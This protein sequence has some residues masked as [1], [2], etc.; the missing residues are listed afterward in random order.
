M[1]LDTLTTVVDDVNDN[2]A[3]YHMELVNAMNKVMAS[4]AYANYST[5]ASMTG[6]VTLT[7]ASLPLLSYSPTAARDL[8]LPAVATTNH[9]FYVINRSGT[10]A[11]TVKNAGGTT[12]ATVSAGE[13][14]FFFSDGSNGWYVMLGG[15]GS[16]GDAKTGFNGLTGTNNATTPNTKFDFVAAMVAL[17]NPSTSN[18]VVRTNTGTLTCDITL[19]AS[20]STPT[21]NGCDQSKISALTSQW[22]HFY[23]IWN[24]TTLATLASLTAPPTGPTLPSGYTHWAYASAVRLDAS[25]HLMTVHQVGSRVAFDNAASETVIIAAT[26]ATTEQTAS[27]SAYVPP[28]ALTLI[29]E[30]L[31]ANTA[32]A[33]RQMLLRYISTK[34]ASAPQIKTATSIVAIYEFPNVAQQIF[35]MWN[36]TAGTTINSTVIAYTIPNGAN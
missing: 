13:A 34:N 27:T 4:S 32:G 23:F 9:P 8:T 33:D 31:I 1:G 36:G 28:N 29:F 17:R 19:P 20:G 14:R 15:S 10:Y 35:W 5:A 24:G 18:V 3:A 16:G 25:S 21:A 6:N 7:D 11:I 22:V 2:L 26:T 12:I 30:V